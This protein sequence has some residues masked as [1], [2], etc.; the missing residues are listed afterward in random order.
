M[1]V[2][3]SLLHV[4]L[5]VEDMDRQ[6]NFYTDVLGFEV[7]EDCLLESEAFAFIT[8]GKSTAM[9]LVFVGRSKRSTMIELVQFLDAAGKPVEVDQL[10]YKWNLSLLVDDLEEA[11]QHLSIKGF[12]PLTSPQEI[13]LPTMGSA[14]VIFYTDP[15]DFLLELVAPAY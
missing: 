10:R 6:L 14:N 2:S 9:R 15:E 13:S 1:D 8:N 11:E 7:F 5:M 12:R 4:D 3:F